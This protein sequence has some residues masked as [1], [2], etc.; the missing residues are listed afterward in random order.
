M[1]AIKH[2]SKPALVCGYISGVEKAQTLIF[3]KRKNRVGA[4][5]E[6]VN[7]LLICFPFKI[8]PINVVHSN[9]K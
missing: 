9:N 6:A 1:P 5:N 4:T 2:S 3:D 7:I 8:Q